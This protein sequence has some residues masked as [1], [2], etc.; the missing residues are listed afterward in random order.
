MVNYK[1]YLRLFFITKIKK[2]TLII[3]KCIKINNII[4][5]LRDEVRNKK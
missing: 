2:K 1:Y 3:K 5:K 4:F